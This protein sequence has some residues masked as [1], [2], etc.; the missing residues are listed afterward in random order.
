VCHL[1][2]LGKGGLQADCASLGRVLGT[3][4]LRLH[5]DPHGVWAGLTGLRRPE[6][7]GVVVQGLPQRPKLLAAGSVKGPEHRWSTERHGSS[8]H[9]KLG[10]GSSGEVGGVTSAG[11]VRAR[12]RPPWRRGRVSWSVRGPSADRPGWQGAVHRLALR[13]LHGRAHVLPPASPG[14]VHQPLLQAALEYQ[15]AVLVPQG[16]CQE[17]QHKKV[18]AR[19]AAVAVGGLE[20]AGSDGLAGGKRP[21]DAWYTP[22][23]LASKAAPPPSDSTF[24]LT[25]LHT[26]C[27]YL[28]I[29]VSMRPPS[30]QATQTLSMPCN[31]C[32]TKA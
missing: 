28:S 13:A 9:G 30:L 4:A 7:N 3:S 31:S 5:D 6:A 8:L 26:S 10:G 27:W 15:P 21:S 2:C 12:P 20:R 14:Q 1:W 16:K 19:G 32:C 29:Y 17:L 22:R 25:Y 11:S 23:R 24:Y 18:G